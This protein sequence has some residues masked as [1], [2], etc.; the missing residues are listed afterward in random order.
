MIELQLKKIAHKTVLLDMQNFKD[1]LLIPVIPTHLDILQDQLVLSLTR[2]LTN[3]CVS[4]CPVRVCEPCTLTVK[5]NTFDEVCAVIKA[6]NKLAADG[7]QA[8]PQMCC[9]L[10]HIVPFS[11]SIHKKTECV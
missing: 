4:L 11:I 8:Y 10:N 9:T 6:N 3:G 1:M 2:T 5:D 7:K